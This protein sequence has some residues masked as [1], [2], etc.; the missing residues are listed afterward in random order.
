MARYNESFGIFWSSISG[1]FEIIDSQ[2]VPVFNDEVLNSWGGYRPDSSPDGWRDTFS[3]K[4]IEAGGVACYVLLIMS[5]IS[6][7]I[8]PWKVSHV[9]DQLAARNLL[10]SEAPDLYLLSLS[11]RQDKEQPIDK[12]EITAF[13]TAMETVGFGG[14]SLHTEEY[15]G[16]DHLAQRNQALGIT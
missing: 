9:V 10:G 4:R 1:Q 8:T 13:I 11:L 7:E 3:T 14:M 12:N 6:A 2:L 16:K 5:Y 15:F